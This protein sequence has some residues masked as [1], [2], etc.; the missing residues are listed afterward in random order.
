MMNPDEQNLSTLPIE[1]LRDELEI[2]LVDLDL[3]SRV[4]KLAE[5]APLLPDELLKRAFDAV[6]MSEDYNFQ[7]EGLVSIAPYLSKDLAKRAFEKTFSRKLENE[8]ARILGALGKA[9]PED[10]R[11]DAIQAVTAMESEFD[12]LVAWMGMVEFLP[13]ELKYEAISTAINYGD[14]DALVALVPYL[15]D[16]FKMHVL[17]ATKDKFSLV[18]RTR[19]LASLISVLPSE[20]KGKTINEALTITQ[21]IG[22]PLEQTEAYIYLLP[23]LPEQTRSEILEQSLNSARKIDPLTSQIEWLTEVAKFFPESEQ[24][25]IYEEALEKTVQ[26]TDGAE[27]EEQL[28]KLAL[29]LPPKMFSNVRE[30]IDKIPDPNMQIRVIN[31]TDSLLSA[32]VAISEENAGSDETEKEANRIVGP[33]PDHDLE[34]TVEATSSAS[35][36]DEK[37][38]VEEDVASFDQDTSFSTNVD[39]LQPTREAVSE[40]KTG[41]DET[42][43]EADE[44]VGLQ[45][46]D[47]EEAVEATD[48]QSAS[49]I[50]QEVAVEEDA[51]SFEEG[52]SGSTHLGLVEEGKPAATFL[53]SDKWTLDDQLNYSLYAKALAEFIYHEDTNPPLTTGILAPWGHGKTTLMRQVQYQLWLKAQN[54]LLKDEKVLKLD[55]L[56]VRQ[57]ELE[58][59]DKTKNVFLKLRAKRPVPRPTVNYGEFLGWLRD[60]N[61]QPKKLAYPTVWF[62]AWKYQSSEQVWAGMAHAIISQLVEQQSD[63]LEREKFWLALQ[64]ERLDFNTIRQDIHRAVIERFLPNI[65]IWSVIT[66][67]GLLLVIT[68]TIAAVISENLAAWGISGIGFLSSFTGLIPIGKKWLDA[69]SEVDSAPLEGKFSQYVRQPSYEGKA[70]YFYE[71]EQDV[72]RVFNLLVPTDKPAVVFI[73]DLD[74]C[75]P[76][77]VAEVIEAVNLFLSGDFP[78]CY[79]V[80]GADAQVVAASMEVAYE[81]L[82]TKLENV[83]RNYGSLGW[84]FMDKFIQ[85]QFVIPNMTSDQ[86]TEFLGE[87]FNQ[88]SD[89]N[90]D[91]REDDRKEPRNVEEAANQLEEVLAKSANRKCHL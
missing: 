27:L 1:K 3:D 91:E 6:A 42:K 62:N 72:R 47:L 19:V 59:N 50:D 26:I 30:T 14:S 79:F 10:L 45:P 13:I 37:A 53:H 29:K 48:M 25:A 67:I 57:G 76:G 71:V 51:E 44:I 82:T 54:E 63:D 5:L 23:V 61:L 86:R 17:K 89:I 65:F 87:L 33:R 12:R 69:R 8:R 21:A 41:S 15:P 49:V 80:M 11:E 32:R 46:D 56:E 81:K 4:Y 36:T 60:L 74:R 38:A 16:E 24:F 35:I 28:Y 31:R 34:E 75:S 39:S 78:N 22:K 90:D 84:Y 18:E 77:K 55:G 58:D 73:D 68:G 20:E 2:A 88:P 7:L 66:I 70:G 85:L 83:T 9:L 40:D 64:A 52:L 43:D